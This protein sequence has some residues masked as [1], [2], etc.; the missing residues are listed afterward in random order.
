MFLIQQTKERKN[1]KD[2]Q[3]FDLSYFSG[4]STK[5]MECKFI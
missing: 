2:L 5:K 1:K 3:T 4:K